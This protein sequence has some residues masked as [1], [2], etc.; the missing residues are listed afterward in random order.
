[1]WHGRVIHD[2]YFRYMN[3]GRLTLHVRCTVDTKL[4][5]LIDWVVD[6]LKNKL[7]EGDALEA[8]RAGQLHVNFEGGQVS[9]ETLV[10]VFPAKSLFLLSRGKLAGEFTRHK[11]RVWQCKL[12]N[13]ADSKRNNIIKTKCTSKNGKHSCYFDQSQPAKLGDH[14]SSKGGKPLYLPSYSQPAIAQPAPVISFLRLPL[15]LLPCLHLLT[16]LNS[17]CRPRAQPELPSFGLPEGNL[18]LCLEEATGS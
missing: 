9:G 12:C 10:S 4:K 6:H 8:L 11:G 1:M 7:N 14:V 17:G 3:Q 2:L 13:R 18:G 16:M 5:V 15:P